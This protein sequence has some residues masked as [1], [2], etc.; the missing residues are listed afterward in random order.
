[1]LKM[2]M[3]GRGFFRDGW[4]STVQFATLKAMQITVTIPD[5]LAAQARG[6]AL[7]RY[8]PELLA[9]D[10]VTEAESRP[11]PIVTTIGDAADEVTARRHAA[12]EAMLGFAKKH[13]FTTGGQ[14]LKSMIHEGHKY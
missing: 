5:E 3:G 12:V 2:R 1:M 10:L 6:L 13:G 4:Y 8:L 11:A 7:D 14:D 9:E